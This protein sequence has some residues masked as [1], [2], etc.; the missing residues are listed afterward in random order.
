MRLVLPS[1]LS[2]ENK[3]VQGQ[4]TKPGQESMSPAFC[5]GPIQDTQTPV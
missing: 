4:S 3:L 5:L 1:H 2:T